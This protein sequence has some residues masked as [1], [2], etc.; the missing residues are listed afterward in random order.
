MGS[1]EAGTVYLIHFA[2]PLGDLENPRGQAQHYLG[3]SSDPEARVR[4]HGNGNGAAIMRAVRDCGIRF[5][6]VRTWSGSRELERRI[7]NRK[8]APAL[9]P[10]CNPQAGRLANYKK[11]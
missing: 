1:N 2:R 4:E 7:K 11:E 10:L 8:E 5:Q 3:W 9:C 6:I